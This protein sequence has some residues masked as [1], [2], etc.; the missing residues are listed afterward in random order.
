MQT[1]FNFILTLFS[2]FLFS[3]ENQKNKCDKYVPPENITELSLE[4]IGDF[5]NFDTI[6]N[7]SDYVTES[8]I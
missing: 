1:Y 8:F 7:I 6:E 5:W 3:C 4:S 2:V